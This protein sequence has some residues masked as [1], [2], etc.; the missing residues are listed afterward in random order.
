MYLSENDPSIRNN[1]SL[2][3]SRFILLLAAINTLLFNGALFLYLYQQL[4]VFTLG[5]LSIAS[6]VL[7]IVFLGNYLVLS[8]LGLIASF[9]IK[10]LFAVTAVINAA[11][12][13][14]LL[15]YQVIL[16]KAMIGNILNTRTSESSELISPLLA[17]YVFFLGLVPAF[18]VCRIRVGQKKRLTILLNVLLATLVCGGFIYANAASWLWIDKHSKVI[19]G[20]ILPWSYI[21]NTARFHAEEI[22]NNRVQTLLPDGKLG[23]QDNITVVL[24]IGEAARA[25]NFGLYGYDRNTNPRLREEDLLVFN[26]TAACSTYTTA[27]VACMLAHDTKS[28]NHEPLPSYLARLGV[29]VIWRSANWGEPKL[30]ISAYRERAELRETCKGE[31]CLFDEIL[32]SNL[33]DEIRNSNNSKNLI[34]LH[35][36]GSHGP[37]Y[38]A[39]YPERFEIFKP[40]CRYEEIRKCTQKELI[41]AYDNTIVYTDY[42]VHS[43]IQRLQSLENTATALIYISDHGESLGENGLYLHGTPYT[44]APD[45]QKE[46]PFLIWRSPELVARQNIENSDIRQSGNFS[47]ANIFHTVARLFSVDTPVYDATLDIFNGTTTEVSLLPNDQSVTSLRQP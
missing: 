41:N 45:F 30:D 44:L 4:G 7:A 39:R 18:L 2:S 8:V 12:L 14:Y 25:A 11:A 16:D 42:I 29:N 38:Y 34:V 40:V 3:A 5:G 21:I 33:A 19:G 1:T 36:K 17:A 10:P 47:H 27:S 26:K 23:H 28:R 24:I 22:R 15:T 43:T 32:L 13:Y 6:T 37:S 35:T 20:K 46:I 9:S 31:G